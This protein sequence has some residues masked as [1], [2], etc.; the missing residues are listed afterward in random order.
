MEIISKKDK[1]ITMYY[2]LYFG[3]LNNHITSKEYIICLMKLYSNGFR[4]YHISDFETFI[5]NMISDNARHI[6]I[7]LHQHNKSHKY[8]SDMSQIFPDIIYK[9][10]YNLK[11]VHNR[12]KEK[13]KLIRSFGKFE[14]LNQMNIIEINL[15]RSFEEIQ[16]N[17]IINRLHQMVNL[18]GI[19]QLKKIGVS[20]KMSSCILMM[21]YHDLK[22]YYI[23]CIDKVL[24]SIRTHINICENLLLTINQLEDMI[25]NMIGFH[26]NFLG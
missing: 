13:K 6:S 20:L 12:L 3:F 7:L 11:H 8:I 26:N 23:E 15:I 14:E 2:I 1:N 22:K 17:E 18:F 10:E 25:K 19:A 21:N 9:K 4:T 5:E 16:R 24:Q